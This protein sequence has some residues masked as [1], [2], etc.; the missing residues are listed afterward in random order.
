M[1]PTQRER[2][3]ELWTTSDVIMGTVIHRLNRNFVIREMVTA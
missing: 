3:V 2:A 1:G